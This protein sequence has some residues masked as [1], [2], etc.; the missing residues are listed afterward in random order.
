MYLPIFDFLSVMK[1]NVAGSWTCSASDAY[2][3]HIMLGH[4]SFLN[5]LVLVKRCLAFTRSTAVQLQGSQIDMIAATKEVNIMLTSLR[6]VRKFL[7]C[8]HKA[9]FTEACDIADHIDCA[10][11]H[12]RVCSRQAHRSNIPAKDT[13]DYFNINS[14]I[15]FLDKISSELSGRFSNENCDPYSTKK[16]K[17]SFSIL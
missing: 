2:S 5:T 9:W 17:Q 8:Y 16:Q 13:A 7:D 11:K 14:A 12:P 4:F 15:P 10:L 3:Y 6:N 1:D